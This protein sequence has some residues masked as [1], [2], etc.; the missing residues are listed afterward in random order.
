MES[1]IKKTI[2]MTEF[3]CVHP[4]LFIFY[5]VSFV[6]FCFICFCY[7]LFKNLLFLPRASLLSSCYL[8]TLSSLR[9]IFLPTQMK[10]K[11][12]TTRCLAVI[13]GP[14]NSIASD[15]FL[16]L[17][18]WPQEQVRN[19]VAWIQ[20]DISGCQQDFLLSEDEISWEHFGVYSRTIL[21]IFERL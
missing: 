12:P 13:S 15:Y 20:P 21:Q 18:N 7:R 2:I 16:L 19:T 10:K 5:S 8:L 17:N 9:N 14:Q 3:C 4:F 1:Q 11:V 6:T